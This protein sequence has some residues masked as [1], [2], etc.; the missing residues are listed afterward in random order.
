MRCAPN[1]RV[2]PFHV[3]A[4]ARGMGETAPRRSAGPPW[5]RGR[6][7]FEPWKV[8]RGPTATRAP[9]DFYAA[10]AARTWRSTLP[11]DRGTEPLK[12]A[13]VGKSVSTTDSGDRLAKNVQQLVIRSRQHLGR[14]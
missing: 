12:K 7:G 5:F 10:W 13:R 4:G 9:R 3:R 1:A 8:T 2:R 6:P 14:N 11:A